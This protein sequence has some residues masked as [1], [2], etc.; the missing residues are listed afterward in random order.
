MLFKT[1]ATGAGARGGA[2]TLCLDTFHYFWTGLHVLTFLY[3]L[4]SNII[5]IPQST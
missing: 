2:E 4:V 3:L 1:A 5:L